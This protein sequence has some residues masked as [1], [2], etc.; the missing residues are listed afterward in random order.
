MGGYREDAVDGCCVVDV[1]EVIVGVDTTT[2][3]DDDCGWVVDSGEVDGA[4]F[5]SELECGD[6]EAD[7]ST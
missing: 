6:E 2:G 7:N 4:G 1:A 5:V 3:M